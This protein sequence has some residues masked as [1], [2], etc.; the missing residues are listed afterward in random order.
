MLVSMVKGLTWEYPVLSEVRGSQS[1]AVPV[2]GIRGVS[3]F[4]QRAVVVHVCHVE[5]RDHLLLDPSPVGRRVVNLQK[6]VA[7]VTNIFTKI[8]DVK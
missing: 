1:Q 8:I 4:P 3:R 5:R 2:R 7:H 6:V